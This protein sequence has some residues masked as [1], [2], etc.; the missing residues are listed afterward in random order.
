MT[1]LKPIWAF[2][3]FLEDDEYDYDDPFHSW[4][5]L[6]PQGTFLGVAHWVNYCD[7][8]GDGCS[9]FPYQ[10]QAITILNATDGSL[11]I[12]VVGFFD[13]SKFE[14]T[15][16]EDGFWYI[17]GDYY[18]SGFGIIGYYDFYFESGTMWE[19]DLNWDDE[20]T[21][22]SYSSDLFIMDDE[23]IVFTA[24]GDYDDFVPISYVFNST[25]MLFNTG[26]VNNIFSVNS[27]NENFYIY[28]FEN[29]HAFK[30]ESNIYFDSIIVSSE[31][32][33]P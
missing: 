15:E 1:T 16:N 4:I 14:F 24:F 20:A 2:N 9:G 25:D 12:E 17:M 3:Y 13:I 19:Y 10:R 27:F 32:Y 7:W 29:R 22:F 23:T 18:D 8:D 33:Y 26:G 11:I 31:E 21:V 28:S 5:Q 30:L 6:S